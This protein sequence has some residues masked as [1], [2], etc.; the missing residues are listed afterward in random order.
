MT[1]VR[2]NH[3]DLSREERRRFVAAV[4]EIK[5]RGYYDE[6]VR[7]HIRINSTDYI[8]KD[9]GKRVGHINPGFFPWH[10]QYLL[11]FERALRRVDPRVTLPYWD[12]TTDHG[13]DS[14]LWEEEFMGGDGRPG[15]RRVMTGP[16]ARDNGWVL[17][18]SVVPVG[19]EHPSLNGH[20]TQ[21][22]RDFLVRELGS[23]IP[24][25][26]TPE[27]LADTMAL[28]VYDCPPWNYT[29]GSE[30]PYESFR[31]H[32][33]G[34]AK[35]PWEAHLGKLHGA[36]HTWVGGH[37]LYIGS[38]NDPVFFLHHCFIDKIWADWM[39][40]HPDVPHYLPAADSADVPAL[41]TKLPPWRTMSPADLLD[42]TRF[43]RYA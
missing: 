17:R 6:L 14:P 37:M 29:S 15:D 40:L 33:E 9:T 13:A 12:W 38:P 19:D 18:N 27:E 28:T 1:H 2:R 36:G 30:A 34:Y 32:L 21:D 10:R 5:R 16:F 26:P 23:L 20:Y 43:Y 3:L 8:D 22:D 4:K 11:L 41:R 25:L 39:Q 7:I 35:F 31:N 42:H 24:E